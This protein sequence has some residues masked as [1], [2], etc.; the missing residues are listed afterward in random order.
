[1]PKSN[2]N[3]WKYKLDSN[4]VRDEMNRKKLLSLGWQVQIIWE[5]ETSDHDHVKTRIKG[6][7]DD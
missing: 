7:L 3:Y 5:C 4:E 6:F 1:M 2:K